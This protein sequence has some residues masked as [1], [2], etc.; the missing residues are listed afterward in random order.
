MRSQS[1]SRATAYLLVAVLPLLLLAGACSSSEEEMPAESPGESAAG[2]ENPTLP[3][4]DPAEGANDPPPVDPA[5]TVQEEP[6]MQDLLARQRALQQ[7]QDEIAKSY[8]A[9]G[10]QYQKEGRL[11]DALR[12]FANALKVQPENQ[13]AQRAYS[14]TAGLLG[15]TDKAVYSESR[16]T[17]DTLQ[18][19]LQQAI[20]LG[21]EHQRLGRHHQTQGDFGKAVQEYESALIILEANPNI[22]ADFDRNQIRE[23]LASARQAGV[24]AERMAEAQRIREIEK[25]NRDRE[26]KERSKVARRVRSDWD[27][28]LRL[29]ERE[30]FESCRK[31][32][33]RIRRSAPDHRGAVQLAE[34]ARRAGHEKRN[35]ANVETYREQWQRA[36]EEVK[37]IAI[38]FTTTVNFPALE[39]WRKVANRGPISVGIGRSEISEVDLDVTRRLEGT[40]LASV[41]WTEKTL[42]EA[43]RFIRN[44]T[45]TNIVVM[46]AVDEVMP[47]EE[48]ILNL[49][50][51]EISA[52]K[53]L[54][55]AVSQLEG[56]TFLIEDGIVKITTAEKARSRKV[57]EFYEVRDLT[58]PINNFPGVEINLNPSGFGAGVGGFDDEGDEEE[59][60][61]GVFEI[62]RL[63]E[64]IRTTVDPTSWDE[65]P[66]N[67][68]VDKSGTLVVRQT[69]ENQRA[70]RR[71]LSDLRQSTGI[72]V[73]IESRFIS[74]ENNFL[75]EVGID[76]RG[77]GDN[78]G[79]VGAPGQ[80]TIAPFDDFGLPGPNLVLGTD[81]SSGAFYS[82]GGGNGDIRGRTQNVFDSA[83]G[84][85][86]VL[87][88]LGG[89]S[90]QYVYLDDTQLEAIL[91]AVQK[92]ERINEVTAP[93]LLVYNT[94]RANLQVTNQVAYVKDFDVEIAQ[95]AVVA[96]PVVDVIKEGVVLD[97]RP[98]VSND[99]RFVTLELRPT[100]ATLT[101]PIRTFTTSLGTGSSV[102][103]EVPELKKQSLKTTVVMP[104]GGTLLLG[105]LKFY[106]EQDLDSGVPV[107]KDIP[108]LSFFFS[109]KG[110]YTNLRDL[111]ILL[112]VKVVIMEELEPGR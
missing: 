32:C 87:T 14:A 22:D 63:I 18:A 61:G 59:E 69:P 60:G 21:R 40:I 47:A 106:E 44:N 57:V 71:L 80:G 5:P 36:L 83:L 89:F 101:R 99:R 95:A 93:S 111:I 1:S 31:V 88:S 41:D 110:K 91:R 19:R 8:M 16:T 62:D 76:F 105:G 17:W 79:G 85:P 100:V 51:T 103:F 34:A 25:I 24:D 45:A 46:R 107:L 65:D 26:N 64:L 58:A 82:L 86:D 78:S 70:I 11:T 20:L 7:R 6:G 74:V 48:R 3:P 2:G 56:L 9:L 35:A 102:T 109:R 77:L 104:D 4:V 42:D 54:R 98:I 97:V 33:A 52:M 38:P 27:E 55:H 66:D 73:Q 90:M 84:N 96:D 50:L 75:Q 68:V 49:T 29:F 39:K 72:Q 94:Q 12:A 28:A 43:L 23:A 112:R 30:R 108:I 10:M 92:Y 67:T 13:E 37:D 81:N 15:A 53:A